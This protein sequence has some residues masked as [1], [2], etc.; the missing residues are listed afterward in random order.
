MKKLYKKSIANDRISKIANDVLQRK[1]FEKNKEIKSNEKLIKGQADMIASLK[2]SLQKRHKM[3][4]KVGH[5]A[6]WEKIMTEGTQLA[7]KVREG[8]L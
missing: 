4:E 6:G 1:L 8:K 5:S 3:S 7:D 2:L